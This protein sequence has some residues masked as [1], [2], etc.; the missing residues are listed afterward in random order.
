[1]HMFETVRNTEGRFCG[2]HH[3][4]VK[5]SVAMANETQVSLFQ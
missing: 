4:M 3:A 5:G 1:M 2:V